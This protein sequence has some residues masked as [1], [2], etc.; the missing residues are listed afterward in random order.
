MAPAAPPQSFSLTSSAPSAP[1]ITPQLISTSTLD[2]HS[3][4]PSPGHIL[5]DLTLLDLGNNNSLEA[6]STP[7]ISEG[8]H[9]WS[10]PLSIKSQA[11]DS[12]LL[13]SLSPVLPLSQSSPG[14]GQEVSLANVFVPLDTIKPS[15]VCPVTAY[16]KNGVR[17]LLHFATDS[18][19]GRPDVLVMVASMLNTAT[20]PVKNIVLQAAVPRTMKVKLQPPSGTELASFNPILPPAAITQ[21]MLLANPLKEKVRMRFKLA[22]TLG[23]QPFTEVGEVNDFPPVDKWG[24]L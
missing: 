2:F 13:R 23:D 14:R 24:A 21:I 5:Q 11:D 16:D 18:P 7:I 12:P 10:A 8:I 4:S 20:Q 3:P 17:V 19:P 22:F 9:A 15:K 1:N 6:T